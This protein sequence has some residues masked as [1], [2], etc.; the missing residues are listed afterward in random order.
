MKPGAGMNDDPKNFA[1]VADQFRNAELKWS[2]YNVVSEMDDGAVVWNTRTGAIVLLDRNHVCELSDFFLQP[3][4][5]KE[6]SFVSEFAKLGFLA[7]FTLDERQA[8]ASTFRQG[9]GY[10]QLTILP[11]TF[12]NFQC[13]YCYEDFSNSL[14]MSQEVEGMITSLVQ[15]QFDM[16]PSIRTCLLYTS[17]SP[18]D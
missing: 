6:G 13:I 10:L 8:V 18:R 16:R 15:K 1:A 5:A 14:S 4:A 9:E 17:P 2:C 11:T 7:P 12:C 3:G